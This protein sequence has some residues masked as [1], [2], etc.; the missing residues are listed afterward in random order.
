MIV[1]SSNSSFASGSFVLF[2]ICVGEPAVDEALMVGPCSVWA[3][4]F[5][6]LFL[7]FFS[8]KLQISFLKKLVL[9]S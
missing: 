3:K 4:E 8:E 2:C 1:I 7:A 6:F 9:E 5:L